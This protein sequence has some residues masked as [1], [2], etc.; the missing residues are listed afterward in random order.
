MSKLSTITVKVPVELK[1]KMKKIKIN[2]SEYIREAIRKRIALE[3]RLQAGRN[4]LKNLREKRYRVPKGFIG[5][6][7]SELRK[8][9]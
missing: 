8:R 2:W 9:S 4:L 1:E 5:E 6:S 7:L 3:E